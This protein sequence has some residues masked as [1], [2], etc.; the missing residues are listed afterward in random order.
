MMNLEER[1]TAARFTAILE[2]NYRIKANDKTGRQ[3]LKGIGKNISKGGIKLYTSQELLIDSQIDLEIKIPGY[4][5]LTRAEGKIVWSREIKTKPHYYEAG[6]RFTKID[7]IQLGRAM[8]Q[9]GEV[10]EYLRNGVAPFR[11]RKNNASRRKRRYST[12]SRG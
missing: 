7:S 4:S 8:L 6:I 5:D 10:P 9:S 2:I 1:R 3:F 11:A 12:E